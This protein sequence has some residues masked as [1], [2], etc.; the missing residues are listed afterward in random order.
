MRVEDILVNRVLHA[1]VEYCSRANALTALR[2]RLEGLVDAGDEAALP[3]LEWLKV[4]VPA[5][6]RYRWLNLRVIRPTTSSWRDFTGRSD[7]D[8]SLEFPGDVTRN[9]ELLRL[10]HRYGRWLA[11]HAEHHVVVS[12]D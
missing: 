8:L 3:A 10:C 12:D 1:D 9:A 7:S 4:T 6:L 5:I 11:E 2:D